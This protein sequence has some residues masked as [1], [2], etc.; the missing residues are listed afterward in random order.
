MDKMLSTRNKQKGK[1][2]KY[3]QEEIN[4]AFAFYN[5]GDGLNH[6]SY[7]STSCP[8]A[9]NIANYFL[10]EK[11]RRLL[12][13][14]YKPSFGNLVN[15]TTQHLICHTKY[16]SEHK[17]IS[18][19]DRDYNT[20]FNKELEMINKKPPID[21][22]DKFG[23][24]AMI[25]FAHACIDVTK[26]VV[27]EIMGKDKITCERYIRTKEKKMIKEIVGRIDYETDD[28]KNSIGKLIELK[29]KPPRT[30][31]KKNKE[32][33][34]IYSQPLPTEPTIENLT[35]TAYYYMAT[36][37]RPFLVYTNDQDAIIFDDTHELLKPNHLKDLY[38]RM[39]NKILAWEN[40]IMIAK[41][42]LNELAM[43]C[44]PPDL[45]HYFYY[46]DLAPEQK[47]LIKELWGLSC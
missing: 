41:G 23:R 13:F 46:K 5:D 7:S 4:K 42:N 28:N 38:N 45:N 2:M 29:T 32:E 35:Q 22:E 24:L 31:K 15:N 37:K 40:M 14:R 27:L 6:W 26:Q 44:E 30:R 34:S 16:I 19:E 20:H 3:T 17:A 12:A 47:K 43:M 9:K 36:K 10:S 8:F 33:W 1:K 21:K 39:I 25:D 11:M 18:L